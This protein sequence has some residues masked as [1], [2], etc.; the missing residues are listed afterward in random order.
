MLFAMLMIAGSLSGCSAWTYVSNADE[1]ET[2]DDI[3]Y[4][5]PA[6]WL[7]RT[8]TNNYLKLS[9]NS[10][11]KKVNFNRMRLT[12][13]GVL[14]E[15]IELFSI[16]QK[17]AFPFLRKSVT[18]K[19]KVEDLAE[20]YVAEHLDS[21]SVTIVENEPAKLANRDSFH[22]TAKTMNSDGIELTRQHYGFIY[23]KKLYV[24]TYKAPTKYYY[25][26]YINTFEKLLK[27]CKVE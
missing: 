5:P 1:R 9:S 7:L 24:I 2:F 4:S 10:W 15:T 11:I 6:H 3:S 26:Q 16:D 13:N 23:K 19:T 8:P 22:I 17:D 14:L 27:S 12:R 20:M 18:E 21:Y 25:Q